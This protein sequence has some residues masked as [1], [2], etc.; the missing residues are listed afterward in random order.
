MT[1]KGFLGLAAVTLLT[2]VGAVVTVFI[3][4]STAPVAYVDEPVFP[5]LRAN[6]DAVAK[7]T[8]ET[9]DGSVTLARTSPETWTSPDAYEYPAA[10]D[11]IN[12]LVRQ[13][14]DMRLIEAK[15]S[16]KDRYTRL[17]VEDLGEGANSRLIRLEDDQGNVLAEALMGKRLFRLTGTLP[18]GTY[19]RRSGEDQSWLASGGF[20]LE[21]EVETWLDQLIVE[22]PGGQVARVEITPSEGEGYIVSRATPEGDLALED[23]L[24]GETI[25]G[26]ADLDQ[27]ASAM[28][29]VSFASVKPRTEVTWPDGQHVAKVTTFDGFDLTVELVLIDDEPWAT[30]TAKNAVL[31]AG[32]TIPDVVKQQVES[33]NNKTRGWAYQINQSLFQRLTKPRDSWLDQADGTS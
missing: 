7:I 17:E 21:P 20:D 16:S 28:I 2:T 30:F 4:P 31:P 1:P 23:L 27:L 13:L 15:T 29:R 9:K 24:E 3:Q 22:I 6:P 32:Q 12:K 19:L 14:N 5:G 33:I 25:K 8:I 18:S 11:K 10:T 26:D